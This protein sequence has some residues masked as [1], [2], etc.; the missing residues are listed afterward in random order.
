MSYYNRFM[1]FFFSKNKFNL[2]YFTISNI[3]I[4]AQPLLRFFIHQ[5]LYLSCNNNG[6]KKK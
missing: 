2:Q 4:D 3:I 6:K 5:L 1:H